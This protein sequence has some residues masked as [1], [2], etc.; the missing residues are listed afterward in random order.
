MRKGLGAILAFGTEAMA[1]GKLTQQF[2]C[3]L[4]L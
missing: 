1:Y 3:P 2:A 4:F